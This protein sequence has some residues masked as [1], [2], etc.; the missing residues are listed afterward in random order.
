MSEGKIIELYNQGISQV[1][2]TIKL[3]SNQI[4][5]QNAM[6]EKLTKENKALA[7][8]VQSLENQ[9]KTN[10]NNSSKPPSSDGFKKKTKSLRKPSDK[11]P[12]GQPG[13]E[14]HTL[15]QVENPDEIIEH[16]LDKCSK[17]GASL[18]DVP[19]ERYI[20]RQVI[21]LPEVKVKVIEH[22]AEVKKCICGHVNKAQF[23]EGIN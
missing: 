5:E 20:K 7:A 13:H 11:K 19:A 10:S 12:G 16:I 3:L 14:G 9:I 2:E 23:P 17:C 4:K 15:E 22:R 18:E 1:I 21:D 8:R 6:I